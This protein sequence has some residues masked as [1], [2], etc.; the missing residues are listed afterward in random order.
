VNEPPPGFMLSPTPL[1]AAL[2]AMSLLPL[3]VE[4]RNRWS[5]EYRAEIVGLPRIR[6][7]TNA[8]SALGGSFSLRSA[9]TSTDTHEALSASIALTCRVGRHRYRIVNQDNP[10]N[11]QYLLREC[12]LCGKIK[13]GP[14]TN[15]PRRDDGAFMNGASPLGG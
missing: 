8:A 5:D 2:I 7:I 1:A 15:L 12:I 3:P 9:L 10:E 13:D 4:S 6:Q 14:T 11:R